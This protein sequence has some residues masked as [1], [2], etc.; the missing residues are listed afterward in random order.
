MP[1]LW[2][3]KGSHRNRGVRLLLGL[4]FKSGLDPKSDPSVPYIHKEALPRTN[5]ET[6]GEV[7]G[8]SENNGGVIRTLRGITKKRAKGDNYH[9][10]TS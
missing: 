2:T 5:G 10:R 3:L 7:N 6:M 8:D 4:E 9:R 1:Q